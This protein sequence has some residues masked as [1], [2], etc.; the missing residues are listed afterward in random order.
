MMKRFEESPDVQPSEAR[1]DAPAES[2][3]SRETLV[4][5]ARREERAL[6]ELFEFSFQRVY[7]LAFR[8]LGDHAA[9][10]DAV[11]EVYLRVHRAADSLDPDRN[12][13]PWLT[14]IAQNVCRDVLRSRKRKDGRTVSLDD[15]SAPARELASHG[16]DPQAATLADERERLV[17]AALERLPEEMRLV[18]LLHDFHGMRH[19]E[20]AE[21]VG[22]SHAAVRKRYSRAL[23]RLAAE[24]KG[25]WDE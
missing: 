10:E 11:Q 5:V 17:Q 18:V 9:A 19:E 20:V 23:T 3:I 13:L 1:S 16:P 22:V 15:D 25:V 14:V 6:A 7:A 4:G 21:V 8:L 24:L 12:P 2:G